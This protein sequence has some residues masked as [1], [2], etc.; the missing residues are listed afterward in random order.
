MEVEKNKLFH[1]DKRQEFV[2][3]LDMLRSASVQQVSPPFQAEI[4]KLIA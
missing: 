1:F 3:A 2:F 4:D